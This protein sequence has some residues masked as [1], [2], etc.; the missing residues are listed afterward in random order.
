MSKLLQINF[1]YAFE[2]LLSYAS[3][4]CAQASIAL[5][6]I[7]SRGVFLIKLGS[8]NAISAKSPSS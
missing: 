1:V 3:E 2:I 4:H 8:I 6:L 7:I 5:F